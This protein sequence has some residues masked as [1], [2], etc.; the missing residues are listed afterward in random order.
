MRPVCWGRILKSEVSTSVMTWVK[1]SGLFTKKPWHKSRLVSQ[2]RSKSRRR[3]ARWW[4]AP[5]LTFENHNQ[6]G[7]WFANTRNYCIRN[8]IYLSIVDSRWRHNCYHWLWVEERHTSQPTT[9]Y[10][11]GRDLTDDFPL[12]IRLD[13]D[14]DQIS[15]E[16]RSGSK[17]SLKSSLKSK[18][19]VD[20]AP[21]P[22]TN[23]KYQ[24]WF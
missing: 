18:L 23:D 22:S 8:K 6:T 3:S 9:P 4:H 24:G 13:V 16:T 2:S 20:M 1:T 21:E 12:W 7:I 14:P 15:S 5:R 11:F 10:D 17:P 19:L